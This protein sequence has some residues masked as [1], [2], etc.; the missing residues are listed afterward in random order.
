MPRL[1][2]QRWWHV[3]VLATG[4]L[5]T[6]AMLAHVRAHEGVYWTQANVVFLAPKTV[7]TPNNIQDTS[8][9][10]IAT[11]GLVES[12]LRSTG[13]ASASS[14]SS[15]SI[16]GTGVR[17]GSWVRLLQ[18]GGQWEYN[19]DKPILEVQV[20]GRTPQAVE[21]RAAELVSSIQAK[22]KELQVNDGVPRSG[23][24]TTLVSPANPTVRYSNG[25]PSRAMGATVL[26]G[27][28]LTGMALAATRSWRIRVPRRRTPISPVP[29]ARPARASTER[30]PTT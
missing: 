17:D 7:R 29:H 28:L 27:A 10:V 3:L 22:L 12:L 16:V 26:L 6:V 20:V 13:S 24:I 23:R 4:A 18:S 15:A 2:G 21:D 9:G 11:A 30:A 14:S 19:F 25:R 8:S 1:S 5:A